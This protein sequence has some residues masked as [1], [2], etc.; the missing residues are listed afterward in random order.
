M[1]KTSFLLTNKLVSTFKLVLNQLQF[2]TILENSSNPSFKADGGAGWLIVLEKAALLMTMVGEKILSG[3]IP[4]EVSITAWF[5][6]TMKRGKRMEKT[7][8]AIT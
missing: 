3:G 8:P 7:Q 5:A 1:I 2:S 4:G 6:E